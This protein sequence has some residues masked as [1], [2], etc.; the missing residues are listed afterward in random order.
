MGF[1]SKG[2]KNEFETAVV[3]EPSVFEPLKFYCT[4][5]QMGT[6]N[7]YSKETIT[8]D[9]MVSYR[10]DNACHYTLEGYSILSENKN[11][12]A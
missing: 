5:T 4:C 2:L 12:I 11:Q 1:C 7:K 10:K 6:A 3:N 9:G 8:P